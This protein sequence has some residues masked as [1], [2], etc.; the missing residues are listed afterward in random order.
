MLKNLK[1]GRDLKGQC[2]GCGKDMPL[3]KHELERCDDCIK[4]SMDGLFDTEPPTVGVSQ[5][6]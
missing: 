3:Q 2:N 6:G 4:K 1:G 5:N